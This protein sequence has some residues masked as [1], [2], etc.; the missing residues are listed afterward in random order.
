M[1]II[2]IIN[3]SIHYNIEIIIIL[4]VIQQQ[5]KNTTLAASSTTKHHK[6]GLKTTAEVN[7]CNKD[8]WWSKQHTTNAQKRKW[9]W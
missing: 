7:N 8:E 1:I 6:Q 2:Y 9:R 3:N 5:K 4:V